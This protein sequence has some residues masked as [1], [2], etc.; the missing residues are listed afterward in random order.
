[1]KRKQDR[2]NHTTPKE[3]HAIRVE[4]TNHQSSLLS[5]TS[6]NQKLK[7]TIQKRITNNTYLAKRR[8]TGGMTE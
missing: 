2:N 7:P 5:S 8:R 6:K 3:G 1:V 4:Q